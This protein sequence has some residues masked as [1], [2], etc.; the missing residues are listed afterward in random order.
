MVKMSTIKGFRSIILKSWAWPQRNRLLS[1]GRR[2]RRRNWAKRGVFQ[3]SR[4]KE[5][6][7]LRESGI[8]DQLRSKM[9]VYREK[10]LTQKPGPCTL[11]TDTRGVPICV[12]NFT[13][14]GNKLHNIGALHDLFNV[15]SV[16][17]ISYIIMLIQI[18]C[19][20]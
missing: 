10:D 15:A 16:Y 12:I 20:A 1:L 5:S 9:K 6:S 7:C 18:A 3:R 19:L 13:K 17:F 11:W 8:R 2:G 4:K 14:Y